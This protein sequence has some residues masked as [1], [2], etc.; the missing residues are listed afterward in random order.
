[1]LKGAS[2][3]TANKLTKRFWQNDEGKMMAEKDGKGLGFDWVSTL[4]EGWKSVCR[5][6]A[7]FRGCTRHTFASD[8]N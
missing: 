3:K 4:G 6:N 2:H 7:A 8:W 1:M 5:V